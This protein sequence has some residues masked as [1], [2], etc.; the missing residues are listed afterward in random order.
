MTGE[1]PSKIWRRIAGWWDDFL[2]EG[3]EFQ[4]NLIMPA[5]DRLLAIRPGE[6]VLDVACGNGNYS[7]RLARQGARVVGFDV[8]ETFVERARERSHGVEPE[9]EYLAIDATDEHAMRSLGD[10]RFDAVVCSMAMMDFDPIDPLLRSVR[11][12]LKPGGRFVFSLPHP[13]FSSHDTSNFVELLKT[14][15]GQMKQVFGVRVGGY[16]EPK[17]ARSI[18]IVNQP[19]P[20]VLWHRPLSEIFRRCF[21]AGFAVDG[22]EEP[23]FAR[24]ERGKSKSPF[25]WANVPEIPPAV[26]IRVR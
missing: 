15:D 23:T 20:H 26:V 2:K 24:A 10:S 6:A 14:P 11:T 25:S 7:R 17:A 3:N 12:L 22:F 8:A 5:T 9:I 16:I 13:A 4:T 18:G 19:E 1:N 21:D